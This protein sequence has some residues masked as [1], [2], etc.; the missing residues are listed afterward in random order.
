MSTKKER[1]KKRSNF[2]M[3][4]GQRYASERSLIPFEWQFSVS[5]GDRRDPSDVE[6]R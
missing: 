5:D 1:R 6:I 2:K 3:R 4:F